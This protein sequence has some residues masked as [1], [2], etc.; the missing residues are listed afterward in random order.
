LTRSQPQPPELLFDYLIQQL[1]SRGYLLCLDDFQYV[2][3]NPLVDRLVQRLTALAA[4]GE[5]SL[6]FTS[7]RI[8]SFV[9]S[10]EPLTGLNLDDARC[11]LAAHGLAL[12]D[13]LAAD[14]NARTDGNPQ[15]LT[16]AIN[17]LRDC[18]DPVRLIAR[19]AEEQDIARYL[20]AEVHK[21]LTR[22]EQAVVAA[23]AILLGYPG[24][25]DAIEAILDND[26]WEALAGLSERCLLTA[27]EGPQGREYKQHSIVQA[28]YYNQLGQRRRREMHRR[29]GAYYETEETDALKAA[30]HFQRAEEHERA[31]RLAT[32]NVWALI[33]QGQAR[34]LLTLLQQLTDAQ[35]DGELRA[36]VNLTLGEVR[37]LLGETVPARRSYE[38]A[39]ARLDN[40]KQT[41]S[42]RELKATVC[43]GMGDLLRTN[44][45]QE[46]IRWL[47]RG[48]AEV[49]G[50][51]GLT[52]TEAALR[53][54]TATALI[55]AGNYREAYEELK[56]GLKILPNG[57][58]QLRVS[59]FI[60][61]AAIHG[62]MGNVRRERTCLHLGLE[63]S[64]RLKD[65]F[66]EMQI[67]SD[68]GIN[69]ETAGDWEGAI[70]DYKQ[71]LAFAERLG[72]IAEQ[73]RIGNSLG[74]LYTKQG[75]DELAVQ[76][77]S[78]ALQLA[79][80]GDMKD[81]LVYMLSS[82]ADLYIRLGEWRQAAELLEEAERL[83]AETG[84]RYP[85]PE[86]QCGW[87]QVWLAQ[88]SASEAVKRARQSRRIAH[89][90]ELQLEEGKALRVLGLALAAGGQPEAALAAFKRSVKL[91]QALDP[92]EAARTQVQWGMGLLSRATGERG[93][94]LIQEAAAE[95]ER[96][97]A[98]RDV[99]AVQETL[100][101]AEM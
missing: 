67:L 24:T 20:M 100:R 83:A 88:G 35:L 21:C 54:K 59:A 18:A 76:Y 99:A 68:L 42:V 64:R 96:L 82:L 80:N 40:L 46:A 26:A 22:D 61:L 37:A 69:K 41:V 78:H 13:H 4:A 47:E 66:R 73:A 52:L 29:A 38:E 93:R 11:L 2:D 62:D 56:R 89:G 77:L 84:T 33:N 95:F 14:L 85:L 53:I 28:F 44:L 5:I 79:R 70:A 65:V 51:S 57:P 43:R 94:K 34:P 27:S 32:A 10:A 6:I 12:A 81:Y 50:V 71:A 74:I 45:P 92:Y 17:A 55:A 36:K 7:R 58:S 91:L 101:N 72:S 8:P 39:M 19:L 75:N 86:I 3:A 15:L 1:R 90:L 31:A 23:V 25:R 49:A 97:G 60:N 30:L 16:L 48:L 9:R 63:M 87:A 98:G